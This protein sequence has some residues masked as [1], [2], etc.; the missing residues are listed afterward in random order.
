MNWDAVGAGAELLGAVGGLVAVIYLAI[1]IKLN[2]RAVRSASID[3]WVSA[4]SLGNAALA[5]TDEF[6][7]KATESYDELDAH[8]R[9]L[10]HRALA[11]NMNAMEALFFH[12]A[13]GVVDG[14]FLESKMKPLKLLFQSPGVRRWWSDRGRNYYDPRFIKHLETLINPS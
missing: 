14:I 9:I 13:N 8:Q 4:I 12:H 3:S 2:T 10:Y 11:Q 7:E 1:Q 5:P 6:I